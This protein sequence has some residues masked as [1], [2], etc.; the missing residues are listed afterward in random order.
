MRD[1]AEPAVNPCHH[2]HDAPPVEPES[3]WLAT[4]AVHVLRSLYDST[5]SP[6]ALREMIR[7][8]VSP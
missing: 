7:R 5:G 6:S 3:P 2:D 1:Q 4:A 8:G